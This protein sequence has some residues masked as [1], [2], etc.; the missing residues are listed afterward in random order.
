MEEGRNAAVDAESARA[1]SARE[2]ARE[3]E[4]HYEALRRA[5]ELK[6][7][8]AAHRADS[9]AAQQHE[10]H[11]PA[12]DYTTPGPESFGLF[13]GGKAASSAGSAAGGEDAPPPP[14]QQQEEPDLAAR[15]RAMARAQ[16]REVDLSSMGSIEI[17]DIDLKALSKPAKQAVLNLAARYEQLRLA[18][19]LA[20]EA[21]ALEAGASV[22]IGGLE[23]KMA[24]RQTAAADRAAAEAAKK[25]NKQRARSCEAA[26]ADLREAYGRLRAAQERL[27][28]LAHDAAVEVGGAPAE[29]DLAQRYAQ[30]QLASER[31]LSLRD[32]MVLRIGDIDL[33]S[34]LKDPQRAGISPDETWAA[35]EE[36]SGAQQQKKGVEKAGQGQQQG[37]GKEQGCSS[38]AGCE[39]PED[40]AAQGE[41][42]ADKSQHVEVSLHLGRPCAHLTQE[43]M[44][45][46][47]LITSNADAPV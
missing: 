38:G 45:L 32:V 8:S 7:D 34:L 14:Q 27:V 43:C 30:L 5:Q 26:A 24:A 44:P 41:A 15:Y 18:Q 35:A 40:A 22:E 10:Q 33:A 12:S 28:D 6:V 11:P 23:P 3:L 37:C 42:A 25:G 21:G 2:H 46:P 13:R 4:A 20:I 29:P 31:E 47:C 9:A 1:Y 17:G 36:G 39:T 16:E 19:E